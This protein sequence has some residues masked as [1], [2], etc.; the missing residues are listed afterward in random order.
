MATRLNRRQFLATSLAAAA[1]GARDV[2]F[3][4]IVHAQEPIRIGFL[5]ILTGPLAAPGKEMENG[6]TLFL[7]EQKQTLGGRP[8]QLTVL[9]SGGKVVDAQA[10]AVQDLDEQILRDW[11]AY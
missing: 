8:V 6:I 9:D 1:I 5:T 7:D 3:P 10:T 4:A 11:A 2:S